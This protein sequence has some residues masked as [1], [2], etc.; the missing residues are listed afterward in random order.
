[1]QPGGV[2]APEEEEINYILGGRVVAN[3]PVEGLDVRLSAYG[4]PLTGDNEPR[5]VVGPSLQYQGE[6]LSVLAEYFFF[7]ENGS[8]RSNQQR[9]HGACATAA[10]FVSEKIQLG[11]RGEI[12]QINV[13]GV[14]GPTYF[15]H[16][17]LAGTF[18]VWLDPGLVLRFSLHAIDGNRFAHPAAFDDAVLSGRLN[19]HT[20]AFISGV[21]FSF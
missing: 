14:A 5:L 7:Y 4:S 18:N 17:E 2:L 15:K 19:S 8:Q 6:R 16:R 1:L 21:Q 12:G 10:Y 20:V 3:T 13:P 11:V 9:T